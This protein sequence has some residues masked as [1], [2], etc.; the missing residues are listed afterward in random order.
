[1]SGS[2][3]DI[4]IKRGYYEIALLLN[5]LQKVGKIQVNALLSAN[6]EQFRQHDSWNQ[7]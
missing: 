1:M 5:P 7:D 3:D 4:K 6:V 2:L